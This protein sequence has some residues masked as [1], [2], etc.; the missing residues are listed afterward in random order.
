MI[1]NNYL[2]FVQL[3]TILFITPGPQRIL[4]ITNSMNYGFSKSLWTGLGDISANIIQMITVLLGVYAVMKPNPEILEIFK[5][6]GALYLIYLAVNFL[7]RTNDVTI[8]KTSNTRSTFDLFKDGF[9]SA[10][11]SPGA[12]VFFLVIFP[13][14][15]DPN[16]NNFIIH[17]IIL[18]TTH[19]F[20]DFFFLTI[21]AGIS[22]KIVVFLKNYPNLIS[23]LS[24]CALLFLAYKILSTK[25]N[26]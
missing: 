15:L 1:P 21:Y 16:N 10:L 24:G 11:F 17:F 20:L 23:R 2:L 3:I 18:M 8:G 22:S 4:I 7:R 12:I 26:L 6:I 25:I 5:W 19:V 9:I 14:F 13:T